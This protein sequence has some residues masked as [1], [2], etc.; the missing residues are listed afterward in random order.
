[1]RGKNFFRNL[2]RFF[3][4]P[5]KQDLLYIAKLYLTSRIKIKVR[6]LCRHIRMF[7]PRLKK[8]KLKIFLNANGDN[9]FFCQIF[10]RK[11]NASIHECRIS[12]LER[13]KKAT[14]VYGNEDLM[15]NCI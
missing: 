14:V 3:C 13:V 10:Q 7:I 2:Y 1:M 5:Q 4:T 8:I 6:I 12:N 15:T 9:I 11:A